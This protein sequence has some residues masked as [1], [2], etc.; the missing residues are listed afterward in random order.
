MT[1]PK[2]RSRARPVAPS[3]DRP[4]ARAGRLHLDC[5]PRRCTCWSHGS[6]R[7]PRYY[8]TRQTLMT[9]TYALVSEVL[10]VVS[11]V[12]RLLFRTAASAPCA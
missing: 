4:W 9:P 7:T 10:D 12:T 6:N 2:P 1:R 3:A 8:S 11:T 5:W